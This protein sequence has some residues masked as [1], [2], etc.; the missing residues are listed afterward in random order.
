ME[1]VLKTE[2][3]ALR[4]QGLT[5]KQIRKSLNCCMSVIS[6]HCKNAGLAVSS[7]RNK[8]TIE[9]I[10]LANKLYAEGKRLQEISKIVGKTRGCI[11]LYIKDFQEG[12][13]IRRITDSE[14]VVSWRRRTKIKLIDH[15]GGKCEV[16][17]YDKCVAALEFH[18]TNPLE[19]D[20][21]V[22]GRSWSFERMKKEVEKCKLLCSNCHKEIHFNKILC[23]SKD[24]EQNAVN[25][26][27]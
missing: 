11:K 13:R 25:I 15:K 4:N 20:F 22:S 6:Y 19:K 21:T 12:R 7:N 1:K 10:D 24:N 18:H 9:Q 14:S 26:E 5:Y 2:I 27:V 16:C 23:S 3:L 8:P 17:G